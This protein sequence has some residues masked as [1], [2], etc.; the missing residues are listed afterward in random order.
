[1]IFNS[2]RGNNHGSS[3]GVYSAI[4][5][6]STTIGSIVSG[7]VSLYLGFHFTFILAGGLLGVAAF[8][9]A[10]LSERGVDER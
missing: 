5:G 2:I 1:M 8:L 6:V 3:L 4:V 9:T 10:R 7:I